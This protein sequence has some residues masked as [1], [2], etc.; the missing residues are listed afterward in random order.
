[1]EKQF[2]H[3]RTYHIILVA[4]FFLLGLTM[5][6]ALTG[7]MRLAGFALILISLGYFASLL[8]QFRGK[9]DNQY[10]SLTREQILRHQHKR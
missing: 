8:F 7:L 3:L 5:I 2:Q 4:V 9:S 1:M 6:F 10:K